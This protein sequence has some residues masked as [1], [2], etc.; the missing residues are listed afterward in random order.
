[1]LECLTQWA[2]PFPLL[3]GIAWPFPII[4][5]CPVA[6]RLWL[7]KYIVIYAY[8]EMSLPKTKTTDT[9]FNRVSVKLVMVKPTVGHN[10]VIV[11]KKRHLT[12]ACLVDGESNRFDSFSV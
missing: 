12:W 7:Y 9:S 4:G 10:G 5:P 8:V 1:M 6:G 2:C 11:K 3:S